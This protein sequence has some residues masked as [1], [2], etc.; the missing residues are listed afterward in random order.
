MP[1][2]A[3]VK[4]VYLHW[5]TLALI[6]NIFLSSPHPVHLSKPRCTLRSFVA[7]YR[8]MPHRTLL[9]FAA[10]YWA[11]LRSTEL[12]CVLRA[13]NFALSELSCTVLIYAAPFWASLNPSELCYT[14]PIYADPKWVTLHPKKYSPTRPLQL[15]WSF[16]R[17][18]F[19]K[20][21][22]NHNMGVYPST[23]Y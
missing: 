18:I 2:G 11:T 7:S 13:N 20:N 9:S 19:W 21:A 17:V 23:W 22:K 10:P 6:H 3:Y 12:L 4:Y 8:G 15:R 1:L 14:L 5:T 16:R